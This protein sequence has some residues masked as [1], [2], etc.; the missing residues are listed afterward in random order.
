MCILQIFVLTHFQTMVLDILKL[1]LCGLQRLIGGDTL[2]TAIVAASGAS[3]PIR[4]KSKLM[5]CHG[6]PSAFD[7]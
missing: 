4:V 5:T 7:D 6:V 1:Y 3:I 2:S